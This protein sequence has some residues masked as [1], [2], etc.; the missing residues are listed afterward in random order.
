MQESFL[1]LWTE[2]AEYLVNTPHASHAMLQLWD[3]PSK[4]LLATITFPTALY[5]VT[6]DASEKVLRSI[7]LL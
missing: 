4:K 3:L 5:C 2:L 6:C 1:R 7:P